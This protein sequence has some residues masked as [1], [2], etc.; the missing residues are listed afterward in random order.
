MKKFII[1]LLSALAIAFVADRVLAL[2]VDA[3]YKSSNATDPYKVNRV[4]RDV[5]TDVVF[6]G[7]SRCHHNYVPS[8]IADSIGLSVYNAGLWGMQ[9]IY[10]QY[11]L[12]QLLLDRYQPKA[13][14]YEVHPIDI[15]STPYSGLERLNTLSP[16]IG[17]NADVDSLFRQ[18]DTYCYYKLSHLYRYNG[19]LMDY[20]AG[21][22]FVNNS[23]ADGG[24]KPLD[25][26]VKADEMTD[27]FDFPDDAGK[28]K[29][30][31]QFIDTCQSR[32]IQLVFISS[33][34]YHRSQSTLRQFA[35]F[36]S[37]A[38]ARDIVFLDFTERKPLC[39][40][41][42]LFA[43]R[44]HFNDDGARYYSRLIAPELRSVIKA[45]K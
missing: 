4:V 42:A 44:G 17:Q 23:Q 14:V 8:I 38:K 13:I 6:M 28:M 12:F 21:T 15:L 40:S 20:I 2:G 7:S 43:D 34:M 1:V 39:D 33:P 25:M 35:R 10:F 32:G 18:A 45:A 26:H 5:K 9:N 22:L 41:T 24:Y 36:D 16:F 37:I 29:L 3:L 19:G 30:F 27:E 31:N 11:S